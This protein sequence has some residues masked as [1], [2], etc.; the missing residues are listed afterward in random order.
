VAAI[1]VWVLMSCDELT[2]QSTS[3]RGVV[4]TKMKGLKVQRERCAIVTG[5]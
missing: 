3:M 2:N 1:L 5:G 4:V